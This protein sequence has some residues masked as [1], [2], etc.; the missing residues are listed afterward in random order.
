MR[1]WQGTEWCPKGRIFSLSVL[2]R[3]C[4]LNSKIEA[5]ENYGYIWFLSLLTGQLMGEQSIVWLQVKKP[6]FPSQGIVISCTVPLVTNH[7]LTHGKEN[8]WKACSS[9]S[10]Q[11]CSSF[12]SWAKSQFCCSIRN[13]FLSKILFE[14]VTYLS[15]YKKKKTSCSHT[16]GLLS[17]RLYFTASLLISSTVVLFRRWCCEHCNSQ[18]SHFVANE[19]ETG[20][21]H[22]ASVT[23]HSDCSLNKNYIIK[24]N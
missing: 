7:T 13:P 1:Q 10:G 11:N 4:L 14:T 20:V 3:F 12:G 24:L 8:D 5:E 17:F 6:S 16:D 9:S 23:D 18:S 21:A 15:Q 2:W 19:S 22:Y